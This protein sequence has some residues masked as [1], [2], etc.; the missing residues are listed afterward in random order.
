MERSVREHRVELA[1]KSEILSRHDAGV[2]A[3]GS[4]RGDHV[5]CGIDGYDFSSRC[6][7]LFGQHAIAAAEIENPLS[8]AWGQELEHRCA[9]LGHEM[10]R[11]G[12]AS[13]RPVLLGNFR[14][15]HASARWDC[16]ASACRRISDNVERVV[17][18]SGSILSSMIA[19]RLPET[20]SSKAGANSSVLATEAPKT[21]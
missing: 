13:S 19:A 17:I 18:I 15:P 20:A 5:G 21:P 7:D 9:E 1:V 14:H 12:I 8:S 10:R 11:L 4:G 3:A 16:R 6:D 2:D